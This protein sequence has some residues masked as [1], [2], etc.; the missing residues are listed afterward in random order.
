MRG[1]ADHQHPLARTTEQPVAR[2]DLA[3]ISPPAHA[4]V[5][6]R[7]TYHFDHAGKR[8]PQ[9]FSAASVGTTGGSRSLLWV[10]ARRGPIPGS[11]AERT[12]MCACG[13]PQGRPIRPREAPVL[14][15]DPP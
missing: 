15:L 12:S 3:R 13:F 5:I 2:E 4:H 9:R 14:E 6:P 10:F 11:R 1:A 8:E 7:G